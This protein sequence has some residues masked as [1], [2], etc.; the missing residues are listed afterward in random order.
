MYYVYMVRGGH[1][2]IGRRFT[3][4]TNPL[5]DIGVE[6][7]TSSSDSFFRNAFK[8]TPERFQIEILGTFDNWKEAATLENQKI[9][10]ALLS[11]TMF[12]NN[13]W[14]WDKGRYYYVLSNGEFR[15]CDSKEELEKYLDRRKKY[16]ITY[17]NNKEEREAKQKKEYEERKKKD[18]A[19]KRQEQY[20]KER[21]V[22]QKEI[23][24]RLTNN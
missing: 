11:P 16:A 4:K 23:K 12:C 24:K 8:E 3:E 18:A 14:F 13:K 9:K 7:F 5:E 17:N 6:Y 1:T 20:K 21:E 2:Y 15:E 10:E 19:K 22:K